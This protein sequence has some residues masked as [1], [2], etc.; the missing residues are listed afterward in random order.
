MPS[1][2]SKTPP[3]RT[4][5]TCLAIDTAWL[6]KRVGPDPIVEQGYAFDLLAGTPRRIGRSFG[7]QGRPRYR[8][9]DFTREVSGRADL[10]FQDAQRGGVWHVVDFKSGAEESP[11]GNP[12]LLFFALVLTRLPDVLATECLGTI[13]QVKA[14]GKMHWKTAKYTPEIIAESHRQLART[15]AAVQHGRRLK[16]LGRPV[17]THPGEHCEWCDA[18]PNCPSWP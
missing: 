12:Q 9:V 10:I 18:K 4:G 8:G 2:G 13:V 11:I 17:P 16:V 7:G 15:H 3:T 5:K 14:D 6:E 1:R